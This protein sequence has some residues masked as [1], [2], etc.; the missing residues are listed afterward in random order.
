[1]TYSANVNTSNGHIEVLGEFNQDD[2]PPQPT[3]NKNTF[4]NFDSFDK[5]QLK[6][7][8]FELQA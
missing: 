3:N 2:E 5:N 4:T 8:F 1:M 6:Q 7:K